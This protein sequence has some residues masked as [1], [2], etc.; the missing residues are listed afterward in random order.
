[1]R[2]ARAQ[3]S[4]YSN[5][6]GLYSFSRERSE[7]ISGHRQDEGLTSGRPLGSTGAG[8]AINRWELIRCVGSG[9]VSCLEA[10]HIWRSVTFRIARREWKGMRLCRRPIV[11]SE[12]RSLA[13]VPFTDVLKLSDW[14][15]RKVRTKQGEN[16]SCTLLMAGGFEVQVRESAEEVSAQLKKK[17]SAY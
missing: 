17:L 15:M 4:T 10:P 2:H 7:A 16:L 11:E 5:R 9:E 13:T 14:R 1:M 12:G 6:S 3:R 8:R